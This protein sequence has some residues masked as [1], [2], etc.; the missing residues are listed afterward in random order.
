MKIGVG[1]QLDAVSNGSA[2][3]ANKEKASGD[4]SG[5]DVAVSSNGSAAH[6]EHKAT[7]FS[8]NEAI[9]LG[10]WHAGAGMAVGYPGTPSTEVL[11]YIAKITPESDIYVEWSTN[12]KVAMDVAM[13]ASLAGQRVIVTTKHV[14]LNVAMDSLMTSPFI[15][16]NGGV[17]VFDADDP[18]MHSSQNEQDNRYIAR[19][20]GIPL[21][22]PSD[23]QEAYDFTRAGFG[24]S[25]QWDTPVML[26]TTTRT[27]HSLSR[28]VSAPVEQRRTGEFHRD[29]RKYVM[30]P[31]NARPRH[32]AHLDR[33]SK[34]ERWAEEAPFNREELR[35]KSIGVVA[36]GISYQY[37]RDVLPD[38]S[39]FKLGLTFPLP[40]ER[41]TNFASKVDRLFV[42]EELEPYLEEALRLFGI[43]VEGK[44]FFPRHGELSPHLVRA[45]FQAAGILEP[46]EETADSIVDPSLTP[47][48]PRTPLLC[49]GCSHA[50]SFFVLR[51]LDTVVAGD[52]GC[53]TL[54]AAAPLS[55]MD[56]CLSMGS[57]VGMAVG[58]A[59]AGGTGGRPV[60]AVLGDSTFL[61]A[62]IPPLIDAVHREANLTVMILDNGITAMTGGQP[63][64]ATAMNIR[65][66]SA[67]RVDIPAICKAIGVT[68][69]AVVDPYDVGAT[70]RAIENAIA[71]HGVSVVI[72]DRPCVESPVKR[73]GPV[74]HVDIDQC[75]GC[76]LCMNLGCPA[77][78]WDMSLDAMPRRVRVDAS[79]CSG[80]TVC[81]QICPQG[82]ILASSSQ[83][84]ATET[85]CSVSSSKGDGSDG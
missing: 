71:K 83:F 30:L 18:G 11:E 68:S 4:G 60:V 42:V 1:V 56:T 61:H 16:V 78:V 52:I 9:A 48:G 44:E 3:A 20:A 82:A 53:Y 57:S 12:E 54:G 70:R 63:H 6:S 8:G 19:F 33:L 66:G 79:L 72:T 22:E 77:L 27:S 58:L 31:A 10:T 28:V 55:S 81:A 46:P 50:T 41:L 34:M 24:L 40:K 76:Q 38:A 45:G 75:D 74:Y 15:G 65:G 2:D 47:V 64:S 14:G 29:P 69:L 49:A 36:S 35:S 51:E 43:P 5:V 23:S 80:C 26:R 39:V 21:L 17:V 13:G 32:L 67:P 62:G 7:L 85:A 25:E 59:K 37:V 84:S 73:R